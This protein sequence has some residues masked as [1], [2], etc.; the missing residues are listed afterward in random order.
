MSKFLRI[1]G[2]DPL[3]NARPLNVTDA[4]DLKVQES[5]EMIALIEGLEGKDFSTE[6][7]LAAAKAVLIDIQTATESLLEK[8]ISSPATAGKQDEI[9]GLVD[10]LESVLGATTD[11]VVAAGAAGTLSAKLRRLTTDL[12]ALKTELAAVKTV[13]TNGTQKVQLNGSYPEYRQLSTDPEP[14]AATAG[15]GATIYQID[16]GIAKM[17]NGTAW[18]VL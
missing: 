15:K 16:T 18:E 14:D 10:D 12:D 9:K 7:T 4:G 2:K 8:V 1:A 17:S 6:D 3:G 5:A 13:L 11:A